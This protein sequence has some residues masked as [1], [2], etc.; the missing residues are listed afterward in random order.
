MKEITLQ[1]IQ[2]FISIS[3]IALK[4]TQ[5]NLCVPIINRI[6][7]KMVAGIKFSGIKVAGNTIGD[8]HH[9]YIASLLAGY[10]LEIMPT[11]IPPSV[12]TID[13]QL[14]VFEDDDWD[15][16]AK[17]SLLNRQDAA[18]NGLSLEEIT[19]LLK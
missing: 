19:L 13:W 7:K 9:R 8:G 14:V 11:I 3:E 16:P 18:Y 12:K 6:Y 15:T 2:H 1:T 5:K 10:T 17:I 4:P